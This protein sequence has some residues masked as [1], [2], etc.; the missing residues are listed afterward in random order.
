[1][2]LTHTKPLGAFGGIAL[3]AGLALTGCA[4]DQPP[5]PPAPIEAEEDSAGDGSGAP[6]QDD[7]TGVTFDA[8]Q[9]A[10]LA[11]QEV[12]DGVVVE[13]SLDRDD[14]EQRWEVYVVDGAGEGTEFDIVG[15]SIVEQERFDPDSE[16]REPHDVLASEAIE[17]AEGE[18]SASLV[19]L[20]LDRDDGTLVWEVELRAADGAE[21]EFD[22]DA[23][24]GEVLGR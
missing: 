22:I 15:G 16:D 11:L 19:D 7:T 6:T 20:Q 14:D 9:A 21:H 5:A 23:M 8:A 18:V 13:V 1:M 2:K 3:I 12:S 10:E 24:T 4:E 17:I